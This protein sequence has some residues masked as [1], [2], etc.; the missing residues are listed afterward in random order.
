M[1]KQLAEPAVR[2]GIW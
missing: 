1:E 2:V